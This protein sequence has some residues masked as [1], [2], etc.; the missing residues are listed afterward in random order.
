MAYLTKTCKRLTY[1]EMNG[2]GYIGESLISALPFAQNLATIV[3]SE[4][5]EVT[6]SAVLSAL[7]ICQNTLVEA[8]FLRVKGR[9]RFTDKLPELKLLEKL[10]LK[11]LL[12][13]NVNPIIDLVF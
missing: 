1:L 2:S 10:Q 11:P 5:N 9:M 13:Q 4:R 7:T 12:S 6:L 3:V 8:T